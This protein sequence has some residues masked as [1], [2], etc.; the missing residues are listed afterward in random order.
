MRRVP[1]GHHVFV[2]RDPGASAGDESSLGSLDALPP[3]NLHGYAEW[4][5][6]GVPDPVMFRRFLDATDYWFGCSDDSSTGSYDPAQECCVVVA[7][8]PV[9]ATGAVGAGDGEVTPAPGIAPRQAAGPSTPAGADADAQ[10]AQAREL[11]AKLAEEYRTLRLLRASMAGE[12]SARGE[13]AREL[14]RQ[15]R[16]RINTDNPDAPPR[17][18][19]KL[20]AAA[21]LLRAMSAPS[22]PE[23]RN[24]Q[25]EV[26]A[27]IEQTAVQQA[28]SSASR[29]RQQGDAR[30]DGAA[31]GG[32][33]SVH[34][35]EAAGRPANSG[36][37]AA[38]ER[39][40]D[41]R[42]A[43]DGDARNVINA[44]RTSRADTRAVVGYHPRRGGRYDSGEDR[45][46]TPEPPGT[47]V[48]SREIRAAAFP[49]RFRQPST[50]VKYNG[51]TDPRVWLNDY[52]LACQLG[53][54]T[55][56][57]VIIRNLPLHLGDS[58]LT[59]L[60]HLPASQIHNWDDLVR[61]FVGNF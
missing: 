7:N 32:E 57:E 20:I 34:A 14:G 49:Q 22:T 21:T 1:P 53:G 61:T 46:P 48:F 2:A 43:L 47:R 59:W 30:G 12:A 9:N 23:A 13:R 10:L 44:R 24:M 37:A 6:S 45:S 38:K 29:I 25:R 36:R 4:D 5:F 26:Q 50:I 8:D 27:L 58:A 54:A 11:E 42:R 52:H 33:P 40:L 35:G 60:E 56:D 17:A 19:Q 28:E 55:S 15:A 3:A 16:D 39:L 31:Q 18:S 41:T 51:E